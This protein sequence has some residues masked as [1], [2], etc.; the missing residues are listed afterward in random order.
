[1]ITYRNYEQKSVNQIHFSLLDDDLKW[2]IKSYVDKFGDDHELVI[3][4]NA[5]HG[6]RYGNYKFGPEAMQEWKTPP[7]SSLSGSSSKTHR[8]SGTGTSTS[9]NSCMV[10]SRMQGT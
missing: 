3:F 4:L 5:D 7:R 9:K 8:L 6:M 1:M 10:R 2:Y